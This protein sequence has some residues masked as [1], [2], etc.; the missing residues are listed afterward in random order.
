MIISLSYIKICKPHL[1][2]ESYEY[3]SLLFV[4]GKLQKI[5]KMRKNEQ[6]KD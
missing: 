2:I 1:E 6:E 5:R 4:T 3:L